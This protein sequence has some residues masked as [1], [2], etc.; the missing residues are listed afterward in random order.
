[1]AHRIL[2][3]DDD[4]A[5]LEVFQMLL[6]ARNYLVDCARDLHEAKTQFEQNEYAAVIADLSLAHGEPEGLE[7][8][9]YVSEY[10]LR[11]RIV[12]CSGYATTDVRDR[13]LSKGA[14][15]FLA[16]PFVFKRLLEELDRLL[17]DTGAQ[18]VLQS[19]NSIGALA[20]QVIDAGTAQLAPLS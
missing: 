16:K 20:Q 4:E 8:L 6:T 5:V 10:P 17:S 9:R 1:M 3:I 7:V 12:V 13:V 2:L 14:D 19:S 18:R 15:V 11:P